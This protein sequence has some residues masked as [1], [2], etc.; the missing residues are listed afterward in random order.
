MIVISER[1]RIILNE[2]FIGDFICFV[3]PERISIVRKIMARKRC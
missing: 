3:F 1:R 2:F